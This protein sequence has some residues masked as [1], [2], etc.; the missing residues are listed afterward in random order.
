MELLVTFQLLLFL[1]SAFARSFSLQA[2]YTTNATSHGFGIPI[3]HRDSP[4]SPFYRPDATI[5]ECWDSERR[6]STARYNYILSAT[7]DD[8][9]T[10]VFPDGGSY[11]TRLAIGTPPYKLY[12]NIDTGSSLIWTQCLPCPQCYPQS[13]PPFDPN[14]SSTY[15]IYDCNSAGCNELSKSICSLDKKCLYS[16]FYGDSSYSKGY[17]SY[18]TFTVGSD[19]GKDISLSDVAFGCGEYNKG[20]FTRNEAGILGLSGGPLSFASQVGS[21]QFSYCLG[22]PGSQGSQLVFG[23]S[24]LMAGGYTTLELVERARGVVFYYLS[25]TDIS[26]D[27]ER[28]YLPPG[29]FKRAT[30][31]SGG[32]LID[33]GATYTYLFPAAYDLIVKKLAGKI[34]LKPIGGGDDAP[35]LCYQGTK[36]DLKGGKIPNLTFHFALLDVVLPPENF[37]NLK[38]KSVLCFAMV[39]VTDVSIFGSMAQQNKNVGYDVINRRLYIQDVASC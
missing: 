23:S 17:F 38:D 21:E 12:L 9:L 1:S 8:V 25:L 13:Y 22:P 15:G 19:S 26:V 16:V 33:S 20:V 27:S 3:I 5:F 10:P 36:A 29:T 14:K 18:D 37:F 4:L 31:D 11:L 39:S 34:T 2:S 28:L 32:I 35:A 7:L 24:A 30:N 6:R